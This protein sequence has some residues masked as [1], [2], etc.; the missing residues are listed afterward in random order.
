[1]TLNLIY[2]QIYKHLN[3]NYYQ[4]TALFNLNSFLVKKMSLE[5]FRLTDNEPF[6]KSIV[7]RDSLEIYHQQ[8]ANLNDPDQNVEFNF[9]VNNNHH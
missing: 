4:E 9:G 3:S 2:L 1:M 5:D 7:K 6:D 8:G